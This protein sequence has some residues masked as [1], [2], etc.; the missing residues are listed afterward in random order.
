MSISVQITNNDKRENAIIQVKV[1]DVRTEK[2]INVATLLSGKETLET[3]I[4]SG[5]KIII[6]EVQNG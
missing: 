6:E 1:V 3:L 2:P 4:H 5:A